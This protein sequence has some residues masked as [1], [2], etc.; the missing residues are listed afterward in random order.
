MARKV[1]F[2]GFVQ[3]L[4]QVALIVKYLPSGFCFDG[5]HEIQSTSAKKWLAQFSRAD[6]ILENKPHFSPLTGGRSMLKL[7][8]HTHD[9][10]F[11]ISLLKSNAERDV[12]LTVNGNVR[13]T[14]QDTSKFGLYDGFVS[15]PCCG[16]KAIVKLTP[17]SIAAFIHIGNETFILEPLSQFEDAIVLP[18]NETWPEPPL[19][20]DVHRQYYE[21]IFYRSIDVVKGQTKAAAAFVEDLQYR[22]LNADLNS[23]FRRSFGLTECTIHIVADD[24][25]YRTVGHSDVKTTLSEMMFL[26]KESDLIFRGTDFDGDGPGDSIGF[27]VTQVSIFTTASEHFMTGTSSV[28]EYLYAFSRYNFDN[29][30]LAVAFTNRDFANGVIGLAWVAS[31]SIYGPPG[32]IC[33]RRVLFQSDEY[34]FNTALVTTQNEGQRMP[35]YKSVITLTHEFGHNFGSP[36]DATSDISCTPGGEYG[37]FI[38]YPYAT[39][40]TRPNNKIFSPCSIGYMFPVLRNKATCFKYSRKDRSVCGNGIIE[41]GEDCDCGASETCGDIDPCCTPSDVDWTSLDVPCKIRTS[42]GSQCSPLSSICCT[43]QCKIM[44][45][46]LLRCRTERDCT[47]PAF[48][49]GVS[50]E[51]PDVVVKPNGTE[52]DAGRKTCEAGSCTGSLCFIHGLK[53]CLCSDHNDCFVCCRSNNGSVCSPTVNNAGQSVHRHLGQS[54]HNRQGYCDGHGQCILQDP[55]NTL[56]KIHEVFTKESIDDFKDWM[57]E[58]WYYVVVAIGALA[59]L[60]AV[61]VFTCRGE[62]NVHTSAYMHGQFGRIQREAELQKHYLERRK[63]ETK[64]YYDEKIRSIDNAGQMCIAKALTRMM[65]FFPTAPKDV[66]METLKTSATEEASVRWMLLRNY[67]FRRICSPQEMKASLSDTDDK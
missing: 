14:R 34:N 48:C 10:N 67:P 58:Y 50:A 24:L 59:F 9:M 15:E 39:E 27:Y 53:P 7:E 6:A 23:R 1:K 37:N 35:V 32:G 65:T 36:H 62:K 13:T 56:D 4:L 28:S 5:K 46:N 63:S 26:V 25:F 33:Q 38:M 2:F 8:I 22:T 54:C 44:A 31:S 11:I 49:D 17:E 41:E 43:S 21:C 66:L 42:H 64:E 52:C 30:C 60:I 45:R 55:G 19:D 12:L 61:F 40:G 16:F 51:C 47:Q 57:R 20:L 29:F 18:K 3:K